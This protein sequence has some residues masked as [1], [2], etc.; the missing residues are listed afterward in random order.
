M[1][2]IC[3]THGKNTNAYRIL[4]GKKEGKTSLGRPRHSRE[5]DI[6]LILRETGRGG[7]DWINLAQDR[8]RWE[9]LF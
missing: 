9:G 8:D 6:K 1:S 7:M 3:S 5:D 2:R 4:V